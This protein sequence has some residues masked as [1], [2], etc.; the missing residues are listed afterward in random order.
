MFSYRGVLLIRNPYDALVAYWN[1]LNNNSADKHTGIARKSEFDDIKWANFVTR[2]IPLWTS[3]IMSWIENS[4]DYL[5]VLYEDLQ[6]NP[7][8]ELIRILEYLR[9]PVNATRL[10]CLMKPEH[11]EGPFHRPHPAK[12]TSAASSANPLLGSFPFTIT[13]TLTTSSQQDNN[14]RRKRELPSSSSSPIGPSPH[15]DPYHHHPTE[16]TL[17]VLDSKKSQRDQQQHPQSPSGTITALVRG[18]P[19]EQKEDKFL[20]LPTSSPSL[21]P[22]ISSTPSQHHQQNYQDTSSRMTSGTIPLSNDNYLDRNNNNHS[23]NHQLNNSSILRLDLIIQDN[24]D[25]INRFFQQKSIPLQLLYTLRPS[26]TSYFSL[27]P[28]NSTLFTTPISF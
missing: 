18:A 21:S 17:F 3:L 11:L 8:R 26:I 19:E 4:Q 27:Q 12:N 24:I 23:N 6:K 13:S 20:L 22:T 25:K 15:H 7:R 14:I 9:E 2:K 10:D 1:F 5:I 16:Q 28:Y